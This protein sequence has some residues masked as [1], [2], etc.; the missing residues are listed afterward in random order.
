MRRTCSQIFQSIVAGNCRTSYVVLSNLDKHQN[1]RKNT[2]LDKGDYEFHA[3][4]EADDLVRVRMQSRHSNSTKYFLWLQYTPKEVTGW[5]CQCETGKRTVGSCAHI[6]AVLW[7]LSL[8][9]FS[10]W[11]PKNRKWWNL[12]DAA[13][14]KEEIVNEEGEKEGDDSDEDD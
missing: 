8:G 4:P 1:I 9:R 7:Y 14:L 13:G 12:F 2:F 3:H 6:A 10:K 11:K 5:Y